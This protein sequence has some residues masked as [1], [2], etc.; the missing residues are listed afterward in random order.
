V[1]P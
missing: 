1:T